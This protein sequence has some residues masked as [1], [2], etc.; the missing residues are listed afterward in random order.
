MKGEKEGGGR[1]EGYIGRRVEG[2]A[3]QEG[4]D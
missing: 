2:F 4:L 3:M 1:R